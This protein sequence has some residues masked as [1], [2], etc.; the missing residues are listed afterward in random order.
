LN[1][2]IIFSVAATIQSQ[3]DKPPPPL[4]PIPKN[5]KVLAC[6]I[7]DEA[8][9]SPNEREFIKNLLFI[10]APVTKPGSWNEILKPSRAWAQPGN[11]P[12]SPH[13]VVGPGPRRDSGGLGPPPRTGQSKEMVTPQELKESQ[14]LRQQRQEIQQQQQRYYHQNR[15]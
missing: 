4:E 5:L 6:K 14:E 13:P 9:M 15:F 11:Q 7:L 1:A 3:I 12:A 10:D 2:L 8:E